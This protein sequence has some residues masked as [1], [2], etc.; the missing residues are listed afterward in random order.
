MRRIRVSWILALFFTLCVGVAFASVSFTQAEQASSGT[1]VSSITQAYD[2]SN[3]AGQLLY[4][5]CGAWLNASPPVVSD[6]A[7]D[8]FANIYSMNPTG[9]MAL[10]VAYAKAI[11]GANSGH[12][13][14]PTGTNYPDIVELEFGGFTATPTIDQ[15]ATG[16]CTSCSTTITTPSIT[17]T[18]T[19]MVVSAIYDQHTMHTWSVPGGWTI[20]PT[21]C[22]TANPEGETAAVAYQLLTAGTY[23]LAWTNSGS[24]S[25]GTAYTISSFSNGSGGIRHRSTQGSIISIFPRLK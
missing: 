1:L 25:N 12:C 19:E 13:A 15:S 2:S 22:A 10:T 17:I 18:S 11:G 8:S 4:I 24:A 20:C 16:S 5:A 9:T 3:T 6:T 21:K 14:P 23:S 7:V